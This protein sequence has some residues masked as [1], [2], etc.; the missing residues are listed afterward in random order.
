M[1]VIVCTMLIV[2]TLDQFTG[3]VK[4]FKDRTGQEKK[5]TTGARDGKQD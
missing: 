4:S 2:F 1:Q 3:I 5:E